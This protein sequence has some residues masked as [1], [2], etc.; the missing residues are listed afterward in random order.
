MKPQ[1]LL[2][3]S[4]L[5]I[6]GCKEREAE[7][8]TAAVSSSRTLYIYAPQSFRSSGLEAVLI[9]DFEQQQRCEVKL[10]LFDKRDSLAMAIKAA[11]D[12]LDLVLGIDIALAAAYQLRP[13]FT[14]HKAEDFPNL[15]RES[16]SDGS[17]RLVPYAYSFVA[18]LYNPAL[19]DFPPKSFGELQDP[20]YFRQIAL[21]DPLESS[22]GAAFMHY[23][24][25]LFGEEGFQHLLGALRKNAYRSY[26]DESSALSALQKGECS[27]MF[28]MFSTA[29]WLQELTPDAK[30]IRM[31]VLKEG[32]Y[33]YNESIGHVLQSRQ[34]ELAEAFIAY[35]LS[36]T[37]QKM[38][39]F[40]SGLLP[41]SKKVMLPQAYSNLPLSVYSHN[42]RLDQ[43]SIHAN[44]S[45]WLESWQRLF[46]FM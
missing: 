34:N 14:A 9:P 20:K 37:A 1:L 5:L 11:P 27:M 17:Y 25:A 24:I 46:S 38:L 21:L 40:K 18:L 36:D 32:S 6:F 3:L 28:G 23:T 2:L 22:W 16:V 41:A 29:A 12:T 15:N 13:Y 39:L 30:D 31:Q 8:K 45:R 44:H 19:L 26:S 7:P 10:Q 4:L 35:I 43:D 42:D 33:L